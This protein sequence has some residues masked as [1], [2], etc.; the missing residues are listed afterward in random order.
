MS[1]EQ[2]SKRGN[3][4]SDFACAE[5]IFYPYYYPRRTRTKRPGCRPPLLSPKARIPKCSPNLLYSLENPIKPVA[6]P[7]L[8]W[9]ESPK[10]LV[11]RV[12]PPQTRAILSWLP[13]HPPPSPRSSPT[14]HVLCA[15]M[16]FGSD[17]GAGPTQGRKRPPHSV[18]IVSMQDSHAATT[19][20]GAGAGLLVVVSREPGTG[21]RRRRR[22]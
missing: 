3:T 12:H 4:R 7:A 19:V 2:F 16:R 11:S 1:T 14:L 8:H 17:G 9:H 5:F 13:K 21:R 10:L 20:P 6:E 15:S 18:H 22:R